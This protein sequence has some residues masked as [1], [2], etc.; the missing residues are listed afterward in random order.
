MIDEIFERIVWKLQ[1]LTNRSILGLDPYQLKS[2]RMF[3]SRSKA[4]T[5]ALRLEPLHR[6]NASY[7]LSLCAR[8]DIDLPVPP[9]VDM[10]VHRVVSSSDIQSPKN[11]MKQMLTLLA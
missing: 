4:R 7:E 11:F 2:N 3:Q 6:R 1:A 8:T 5:N 9:P 10:Y